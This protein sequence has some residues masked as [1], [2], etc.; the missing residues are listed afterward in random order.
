MNRNLNFICILASILLFSS[1]TIASVNSCFQIFRPLQKN[2]VEQEREAWQGVLTDPKFHDSQNYRYLVHGIVHSSKY[3][4]ADI[5]QFLNT[6]LQGKGYLLSA[7]FVS[8]A[9]KSR[10]V[11]PVGF[12]IKVAAENILAAHPRDINIRNNYF[13]LKSES[14]AE[15]SG[16]FRARVEQRLYDRYRKQYSIKVL[17]PKELIAQTKEEDYNE[18]VIFNH[19]ISRIEVVGIFVDS[20]HRDFSTKYA[21]LANQIPLIAESLGIPIIDKQP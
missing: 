1:T 18:V 4:L 5:L 16:V 17:S 14:P 2:E 10:V 19:G 21:H 3:S 6:D 9:S 20:Q 7:S 13:A 8:S 11:S 15:F 12:I